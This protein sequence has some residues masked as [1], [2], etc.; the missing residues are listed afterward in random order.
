MIERQQEGHTT[1][2]ESFLDHMSFKMLKVLFGS[3]GDN[4]TRGAP[5]NGEIMAS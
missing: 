3:Y 2:L 4:I 5:G 1:V